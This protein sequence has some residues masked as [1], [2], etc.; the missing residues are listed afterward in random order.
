MGEMHNAIGQGSPSRPS[1]LMQSQVGVPNL[2]EELT[3]DKSTLETLK[4]LYS[5]KERAVQ[6]EDFD[7]AKRI[8]ETIDRLKTVSTQISQL[9]ERKRMAIQ[10]EDYEAAKIIK[11]EIEKLK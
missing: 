7:E 9:E 2:E 10:S 8:K 4:A 11:F 3:L 6:M 1:N 5:A